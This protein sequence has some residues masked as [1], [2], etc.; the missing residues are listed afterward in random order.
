M[1]KTTEV[2]GAT[3]SRRTDKIVAIKPVSGGNEVTLSSTSVVL[4]TKNTSQSDFIFHSDGSISYP[5]NQFNTGSTD[6]V[7]LVSGGLFWPSASAIASGQPFHST[8][9][10]STTIAGVSKTLV[11]HVTVQ[12]GGTASV[13]VPA[14]SYNATIVNMTMAET[15][16]GFRVS[17]EIRT[18][19]ASGVGPVKS[20]VIVH[21]AGVSRVSAE[22]QLISFTKG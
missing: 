11:A 10:I 17:T 19:L 21:A 12:G 2:T 20:E 9:K 8:L 14:G 7:K 5:F 22:D 13:T 18:W 15:V 1:Y 4:G 16:E 6:K 3:V